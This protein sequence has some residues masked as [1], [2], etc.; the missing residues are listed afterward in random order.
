MQSGT[1]NQR[2][3]KRS[4]VGG[5][6]LSHT[7]NLYGEKI[8]WVE[9]VQSL[10]PE[11]SLKNVCSALASWGLEYPPSA[12]ANSELKL[13]CSNGGVC[14]PREHQEVQRPW[15]ALEVLPLCGH[16]SF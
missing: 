14:N 7:K 9:V 15:V 2:W 6:D 1:K 3:L 10:V 16:L 5:D 11:C 8:Q 4:S 13:L 12:V